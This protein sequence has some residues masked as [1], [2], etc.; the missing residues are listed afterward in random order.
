MGDNNDWNY[1]TER[2]IATKK[3][4]KLNKNIIRN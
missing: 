3:E 1:M 2:K 4:R